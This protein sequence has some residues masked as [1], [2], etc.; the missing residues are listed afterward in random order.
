MTRKKIQNHLDIGSNDP[1]NIPILHI[2]RIQ[3]LIEHSSQKNKF[4]GI[5]SKIDLVN[6]ILN[7]LIYISLKFLNFQKN[8]PFIPVDNHLMH[9][10]SKEN[11]ILLIKEVNLAEKEIKEE[12]DS[13]NHKKN[14][15]A[16]NIKLKP[17]EKNREIDGVQV[18]INHLLILLENMGKLNEIKL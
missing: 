13:L 8:P 16:N 14:E 3:K 12:L 18:K 4:S 17:D 11:Y 5:S 15:F 10:S 7:F 2:S 6:E 9:V 1:L